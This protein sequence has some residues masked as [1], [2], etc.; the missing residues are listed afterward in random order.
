MDQTTVGR[1]SGQGKQSERI[2]NAGEACS[3][4]AWRMQNYWLYGTA[5]SVRKTPLLS[6][7]Y[8]DRLGTNIGKV[9]KRGVFGRP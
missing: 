5:K 6:H 3:L 1:D 4:L 9:E 2:L 7:F 8:Q